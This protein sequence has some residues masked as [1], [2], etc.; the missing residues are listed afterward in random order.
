[1]ARKI[2]AMKKLAA[3]TPATQTDSV[4]PAW[5]CGFRLLAKSQYADRHD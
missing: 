1:M 3:A 4:F 5:Q 2:V